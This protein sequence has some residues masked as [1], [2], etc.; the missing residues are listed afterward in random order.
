MYVQGILRVDRVNG[1]EL[2][3]NSRCDHTKRDRNCVGTHGGR[4]NETSKGPTPGGKQ[5]RKIM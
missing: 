3:I 2:A 1:R 5:T 4:Q